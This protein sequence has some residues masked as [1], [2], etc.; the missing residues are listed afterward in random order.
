MKIIYLDVETGGL[1]CEIN[2]LL[3]LSGLIEIDGKVKEKFDMLIK[4]FKNSKID[5][6]ALI[7]QNK[8]MEYI[9]KFHLLEDTEAYLKFLKI[10]D[11]YIDKYNKKDKFIVCGY[12]VRFDISFINSL[13]ERHCNPFLFSYFHSTM[14]DP[15]NLIS[16]FQAEGKLPFLENNKL[17]T[18]CDFF[19]IKLKKAHDGLEDIIATRKLYFKLKKNMKLLKK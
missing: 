15:I 18:W 7:V 1:N 14:I 4:P 19:E 9:D 12:N 13:F 6:E 17:K 16:I 3:Q 5:Q 8:T 11:K 2:P 10:L